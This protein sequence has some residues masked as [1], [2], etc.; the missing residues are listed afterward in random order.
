MG[1]SL[2][3]NVVGFLENLGLVGI[4]TTVCAAANFVGHLIA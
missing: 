1:G 4:A 3:I 2:P